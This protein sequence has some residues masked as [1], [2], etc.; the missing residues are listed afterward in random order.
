MAA[1]T[2][3]PACFSGTNEGMLADE[4]ADEIGAV[5]LRTFYDG[6]SVKVPSVTYVDVAGANSSRIIEL[7]NLLVPMLTLKPGRNV[8]V[9]GDDVVDRETG[10][11]C[12][13]LKVQVRKLSEHTAETGVVFVSG[14][15]T[16]SQRMYKLVKT[17]KGWIVTDMVRGAI[18]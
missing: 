11:P 14:R 16:M 17:E 8:E 5:V 13:V 10:L 6:A 7:A 18:T 3:L 12:S 1:G 4:T 2:I 15:A 9:I